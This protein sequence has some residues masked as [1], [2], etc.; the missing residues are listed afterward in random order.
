M[1]RLI[2]TLAVCLLASCAGNHST[3]KKG[4]AYRM[5]EF[6]ASSV[7]QG[8][9]RANVDSDRMHS[10]YGLVATGYDR[11]LW[12][13][14]TYTISAIP[15]PRLAAYGFEVTYH[16]TLTNAPAKSRR[17]NHAVVQRADLAGQRVS[18]K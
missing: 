14:E 1:H 10:G 9:L 16:G 15:V 12:E 11:S 3:I 13:T 2:C 17:I 5:D 7:A 4:F 18:I 8:A 6:T